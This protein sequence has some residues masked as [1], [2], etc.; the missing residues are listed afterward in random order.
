MTQAYLLLSSSSAP[1]GKNMTS[2][3]Q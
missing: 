2:S 3:N 1:I